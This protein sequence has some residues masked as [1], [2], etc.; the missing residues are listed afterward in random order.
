MRHDADLWIQWRAEILAVV[1]LFHWCT[2]LL[3]DAI[4]LESFIKR[5][6]YFGIVDVEV[7]V[8]DILDETCHGNLSFAYDTDKL[9]YSLMS[10]LADA[11]LSAKSCSKACIRHELADVPISVVGTGRHGYTHCGLNTDVFLWLSVLSCSFHDFYFLL[12]Y[13]VEDVEVPYVCPMPYFPFFEHDVCS[14]LCTFR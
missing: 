13:K 14:I 9:H 1:F 7:L 6:L 11:Y 4:C 12:L 2:V 10:F 8:D 5:S 3:L